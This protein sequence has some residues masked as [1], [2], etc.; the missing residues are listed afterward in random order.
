MRKTCKWGQ[1][2]DI[3]LNVEAI[4]LIEMFICY[5]KKS[6]TLCKYE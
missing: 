4:F 2:K 3:K 5:G 1:Q 6:S